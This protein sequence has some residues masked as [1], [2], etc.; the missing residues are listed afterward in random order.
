M[1]SIAPKKRK[2]E[3]DQLMEIGFTEDQATFALE[4]N[5]NDVAKATEFLIE[6]VQKDSKNKNSNSKKKP[7]NKSTEDEREEENFW[8]GTEGFLAR[9]YSYINLRFITCPSYCLIW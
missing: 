9:F 7:E 6:N 3:V 4:A 8:I 1:Y 2:K 5:N